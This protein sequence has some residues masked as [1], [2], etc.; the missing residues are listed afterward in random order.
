ML[1][2]KHLTLGCI[3]DNFVSSIGELDKVLKLNRLN[4]VI[5][6]RIDVIQH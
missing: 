6:N 5:N 2:R 1:L 4:A 3:Q